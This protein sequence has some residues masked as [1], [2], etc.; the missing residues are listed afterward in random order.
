MP[1]D[2]FRRFRDHFTR[3]G[4]PMPNNFVVQNYDPP[5]DPLWPIPAGK[6]GQ[7][8]WKNDRGQFPA[9]GEE[10]KRRYRRGSYG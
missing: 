8:K 7:W 6:P 1:Y 9:T 3:S 2:T 4:K 5:L 10:V